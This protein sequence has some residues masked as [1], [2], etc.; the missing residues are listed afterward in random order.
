MTQRVRYP[1]RRFE[2]TGRLACVVFV[3]LLLVGCASKPPWPAVAETDVGP[4]SPGRWVWAELFVADVLA[5]KAFYGQVFGWTFQ[6][7][8]AGARPYTLI[9][10]A[11]KPIAGMLPHAAGNADVQR[12]RWLAVMS[13][14]DVQEAAATVDQ[15]GGEVI[16]EPVDLP[17]RGRVSLLADPEAARF[18]VM[19]SEVGDPADVMPA[20]GDWLWRELWA[21][22]ADDMAAFYAALAPYQIQQ[23]GDVAGNAEVHL[24]IDGYPRAGV[25]EHGDSDLPSTWLHYVRVADLEATLTRVRQAGGS[26]L[27]EPSPAIRQGRVAIV[28]DPLGASI[29]LA[30]WSETDLAGDVR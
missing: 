13:V 9:R 29:G 10:N 18:G 19:T 4:V 21:R 2:G 20:F 16:V 15:R 27:V 26:V 5:A 12:A 24:S 3:L 11:G 6:S 22:S 1:G 7:F 8:G 14:A 25:I 30:E 17:G 28:T 23:A